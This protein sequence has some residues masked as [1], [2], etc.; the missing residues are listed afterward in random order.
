M[1]HFYGA[2]S[3]NSLC[4]EFYNLNYS[5][6]L[7]TQLMQ[8]FCIVQWLVRSVELASGRR[9][10]LVLLLLLQVTCLTG[11]ALF[12]FYF[13]FCYFFLFYDAFFVFFCCKKGFDFIYAVGIA[14]IHIYFIRLANPVECS[15]GE[16]PSAP[17][18]LCCHSSSWRFASTLVM[19]GVCSNIH[20]C[21]HS[22][23]RIVRNFKMESIFFNDFF[24]DEEQQ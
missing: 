8:L 17:T 13:I 1:W 12:L 20:I 3:I 10:L 22:L 9:M 23:S 18:Y 21:T 16:C 2:A 19:L 11:C 5:K 4:G 14:C 6:V 24:K 7:L 15:L